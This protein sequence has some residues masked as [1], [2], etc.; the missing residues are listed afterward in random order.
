MDEGTNSTQA[1]GVSFKIKLIINGVA[2]ITIHPPHSLLESLVTLIRDGKYWLINI[3]IE[4]VPIIAAKKYELWK[5][6]SNTL[7]S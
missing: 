6:F 7:K 3:W 4:N 1:Y 2:P 5:K